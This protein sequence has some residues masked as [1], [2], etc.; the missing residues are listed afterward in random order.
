MIQFDLFE[1][2]EQPGAWELPQK[3]TAL[4]AATIEVEPLE[5]GW[6]YGA[7]WHSRTG[8]AGGGF[9]TKSGRMAPTRREAIAAAAAWLGEELSRLPADRAKVARWAEGVLA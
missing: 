6:G 5:G 1:P 3:G 9:G 7:S 2:R 4:P 8:M